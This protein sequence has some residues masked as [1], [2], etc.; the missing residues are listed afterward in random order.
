MFSSTL[1]LPKRLLMPTTLAAAV[2]GRDGS[3]SS[4]FGMSVSLAFTN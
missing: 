4:C 1:A 2:A 3:G